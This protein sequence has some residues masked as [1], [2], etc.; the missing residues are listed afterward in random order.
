MSIQDCIFLNYA[1]LPLNTKL[2]F[3]Y[4]P[5][6]LEGV[7]TA[8]SLSPAAPAMSLGFLVAVSAADT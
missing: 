4:I 1:S 8:E 6:D 2:P 5:A 3:P 7:P